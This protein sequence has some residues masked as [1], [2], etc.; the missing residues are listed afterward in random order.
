MTSRTIRW[1]VLEC[2]VSRFIIMRSPD[3]PRF[4]LHWNTRSYEGKISWFLFS[5]PNLAWLSTIVL[6]FH[7]YSSNWK[8]GIRRKGWSLFHQPQTSI[9][10]TTTNQIGEWFSRF[11]KSVKLL[12]RLATLVW[13]NP[14]WSLQFIKYLNHEFINISTPKDQYKLLTIK[15]AIKIVIVLLCVRW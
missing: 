13:N 4:S 11:E 12:W 1:Q 15:E 2:L 6:F 3:H 5:C 8:L 10:P 14:K 7:Y 9:L